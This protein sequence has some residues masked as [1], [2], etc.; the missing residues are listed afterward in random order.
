MAAGPPGGESSPQQESDAFRADAFIRYYA[1]NWR[2]PK[3][4]DWVEKLSPLLKSAIRMSDAR[5]EVALTAARAYDTLGALIYTQTAGDLV[6]HAITIANDRSHKQGDI[7]N[8]LTNHLGQLTL[9]LRRLQEA[10]RSYAHLSRAVSG[11]A[12]VRFVDRLRETAGDE[13]SSSPDGSA[14]RRADNEA[15]AATGTRARRPAAVAGGG[16]DP[17]CTELRL[18]GKNCVFFD[19]LIGMETP[20]EHIRVEF[21]QPMLFPALAQKESKGFMLYGPPGTGK[22]MLMKASLSE[23]NTQLERVAQEGERPDRFFLLEMRAD[24]VKDKYVGGTEQKIRAKFKCAEDLARTYEG[25]NQGTTARSVVLIDE[26]ETLAGTRASDNGGGGGGNS[27][28]ALLVNMDGIASSAYV[29]VVIAT[30]LPEKIDSAVR[31]RM[32]FEVF[33]DLP[34][35]QDIRALVFRRLV[36]FTVWDLMTNPR[37]ANADLCEP[38]NGFVDLLEF[39]FDN[40]ETV[41]ALMNGD[42]RKIPVSEEDGAKLGLQKLIEMAWTSL[43]DKD[44]ENENKNVPQSLFETHASNSDVDM[45]MTLLFNT[46]GA[47]A[48]EHR[49]FFLAEF[50]CAPNEEGQE[51]SRPLLVD[52]GLAP[53]SKLNLFYNVNKENPWTK[54]T[55]DNDVPIVRR[56]KEPPKE[57][58]YTQHLNKYV[59]TRN[60]VEKTLWFADV[61]PQEGTYVMYLY[62]YDDDNGDITLYERNTGKIEDLK[63]QDDGGSIS[64]NFGNDQGSTLTLTKVDPGNFTSASGVFSNQKRMPCLYVNDK[65]FDFLWMIPEGALEGKTYQ[66]P[67]WVRERVR[68]FTI[69]EQTVQRVQKTSTSS[70]DPKMYEQIAGY[71]QR[72]GLAVT[73]SEILQTASGSENA[74]GRAANSRFPSTTVPRRRRPRTGG[75][76]TADGNHNDDD[77]DEESDTE[78]RWLRPGW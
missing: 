16:A 44:E 68:T 65:T 63:F 67:S 75:R 10:W 5:L 29:S 49:L 51:C 19:D 20:K 66:P 41:E 73:H 64:Y 45:F 56:W 46:A 57:G 61:A 62:N 22:T 13:A 24:E 21:I 26:A 30:N 40:G 50:P 77:D 38:G 31:R 12:L 6:Q 8:V 14:A 32:R 25:E 47:E 33:V 11:P 18:V 60:G 17:A 7:V 52:P 72:K 37:V 58:D 35:V 36:D 70:F 4:R 3:T 78:P 48:L 23:L 53:L 69:S 42:L 15:T 27:V 54:Q 39:L 1:E 2:T 34:Q 55:S 28:Q 43:E 71:A 59:Y 76:A 74:Q 9:F